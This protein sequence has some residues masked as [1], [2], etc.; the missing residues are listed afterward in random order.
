MATNRTLQFIGFA[1]GNVPVQI[2]ARINNTTVFSG[3]VDTANEPIANGPVDTENF[4]YSHQPV[5]FSV[6]NSDLFPTDFSG[7][8]PMS[9]AVSGGD[10]VILGS[11]KSNFMKN[12]VKVIAQ[13]VMH[14]ASIDETTLTIGTIGQ[15]NVHVGQFVFSPELSVGS[16]IVEG[17]GLTWTLE[18]SLTVPSSK[19][20]GFDLQ[21]VPLDQ[22]LPG[23]ATVFVNCF[24]GT[25]TS[26]DVSP[27]RFSSVE[28]NG[29]FRIPIAT[30]GTQPL[31]ILNGQTANFNLNVSLGDTSH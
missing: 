9:I 14:D 27:D 22:A 29:T 17:S 10:G 18:H 24:N 15:G 11:V 19:L 28:I 13:S 7:S 23:N 25:P 5:L 4:P 20:L 16:K 2:T 8:Y 26:S 6:E 30:L 1:Y 3:T 21:R 31:R 12:T